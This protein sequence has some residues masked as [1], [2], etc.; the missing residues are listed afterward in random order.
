MATDLNDRRD[1]ET[2]MWDE[3]KKVRFGML[4]LTGEPARHF[5]PMTAMAERDNGQIWFFSRSDADLATDAQTRHGAM[6]VVQA[7]DNDFQACIGGDLDV[8]RD[9]ARIDKYWNPM[10]AAWFPEGKDAA[11]LTLLRLDC[12]DAQLWI[13]QGG[14]VKYLFETAKAN[15][16]HTTPDVGGRV[17]LDLN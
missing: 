14:T 1:V 10:V 7:A 2:R 5:Q 8:C 9:Q 15:L 13:S 12:G 16:T 3:I 11:S 17:N 6:F 4:G